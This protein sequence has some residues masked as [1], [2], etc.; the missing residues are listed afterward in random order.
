MAFGFGRKKRIFGIG[1]D[2][3]PYSLAVRLMDEGRMPNLK[4]LAE[5][6]A[7]KR[8]NSVYPT[9]S[10]VAWASFMTGVGPG[11]FGVF[12]FADLKPNFDIAIPNGSNLRAP[13]IF[14]RLSDKGK[15]FV[16]LSVP[17]TYPAPK[18]NG[19][20]V[21][22]FL[23]PQ[24]DERAVSNPDILR[25]LRW[26]QYEIDID[27][28]VAHESLD[29]FQ[30]DLTRVSTRRWKTALELMDSEPW[31]L[32]FLH[33]METDRLSHFMWQF[34]REPDSPRGRFVLDFFSKID[35]FIG[36]VA[37]R[38]DK[39]SEMF[40]M[41]DHGFCELKYEVQVNRWLKAEGYLDY[42]NDPAK[43]FRAVKPG[44]RAVALA[45]GRI[46]L[47]TKFF[48]EQGSVGDID[49]ASLRDE[50]MG[51]LREWKHPE[52][53]EPICNQVLTRDEA[54]SGPYTQ[55]A[56][57]IVID[58]TDGYDLKARL[59]DGEMFEKGVLSGM[60][61]YHDAMLVTGKGLSDV[62]EADSVTEVGAALARRLLK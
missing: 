30:E 52:T 33:V 58:P 36:Q 15:S 62:A 44:S 32:F 34:L 21:S 8:T 61:T 20:L 35:E 45:P 50:I 49:F 40:V 13:T 60:H 54:F 37:E 28:A 31:E 51:K 2:G 1:L 10:N 26:T 27:P 39:R 16:S 3:C 11:G 48:W 29:R 47:L 56:P 59:G 41:S 9:V 25:K 14:K 6:G 18:L 19:L 12:G 7:C 22:G 38:L 17:M 42:E 24:L 53:G 4:R 5:A 55:R 46:H 43:M 57:D 23:A